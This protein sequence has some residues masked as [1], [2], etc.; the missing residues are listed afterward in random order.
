MT[1][2]IN[3]SQHEALLEYAKRRSM[4]LTVFRPQPHQDDFFRLYAKE[5]LV[6]GGN[7]SGKSTCAS[8]LFAATATDTPITLSDGTIVESRQTWQKNRCL[9]MWVIG[10]DSKHIGQTIFRLLF[11]AGL[12]KTIRDKTTGRLRAYREWEEEDR[13]REK[14]IKDSNPLIPKS[15]V[16][17]ASWDWENKKGK[18]FKSVTIWHPQTHEPLANIYAFSSK[19]EP[20][21]GDPVDVIWVDEAIQDPAHY[22]EWFARLTDRRGRIFW[23]SWPKVDNDALSSLTARAEE[24]KVNDSPAVREIVLKTSDNKAMPEQNL[25]EFLRGM[26]ETTRRARDAGEYITDLLRAYPLFDPKVH[27]VTI[28]NVDDIPKEDGVSRELSKTDGIPPREWTRDLIL[29]P[30]TNHPAVLLCAV[31]PP[32]YG[33]YLI[34]Y[35]EIYPGR[36]DADEIADIVAKEA[37]TRNERYYR[38]IIDDQAGRQ[39]QM[40]YSATVADNYIRAFK[41]VR[42]SSTS[43]G[44]KF[45]PGCHDVGGRMGCLRELMHFQEGQNYPTLRVVAHRC[46]NL[47]KQLKNY[48]LAAV[49]NDVKEDRPAPGQ[50]LDVAVALEYWAASKPRY[51]PF[52]L[53][54]EDGGAAYMNWLKYIRPKQKQGSSSQIGPNYAVG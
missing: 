51:V 13:A 7:R 44:Y 23:S 3:R 10:Y 20:K 5:F 25:Q 22:S 27:C 32:N 19:A 38:F 34:A 33:N 31:P 9:D 4:S 49:N 45:Y 11:K 24:E 37:R 42:L 12:F 17:P 43:L 28:G 30:G 6:R 1:M 26:D 53:T 29:D 21:A 35:Q 39:Q 40:G 54:A 36:A 18:E 8:V 50:R 48:K 15:F 2:E 46:P 41:R 52:K 14:E 47:V 16:D